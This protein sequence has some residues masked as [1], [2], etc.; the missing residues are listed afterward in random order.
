M[1]QER[2]GEVVI[3]GGRAHRPAQ[4][5]ALVAEAD[6]E[7]AIRNTTKTTGGKTPTSFSMT[8]LL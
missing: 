3:A 2:W 6:D 7:R 1:M 5:P 4:L 8:I